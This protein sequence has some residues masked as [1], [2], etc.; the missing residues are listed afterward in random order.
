MAVRSQAQDQII[1]NDGSQITGTIVGVAGGQVTVE[2]HTPNG[3]MA[4][5]VYYLSTSRR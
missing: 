1:K 3:G 4:R 5:G 2:S